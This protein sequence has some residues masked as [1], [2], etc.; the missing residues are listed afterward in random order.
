MSLLSL[1]G[2]FTQRLFG[3]VAPMG[4]V[5]LLLVLAAL[6]M[7]GLGLFRVADRGLMACAAVVCLAVAALLPALPV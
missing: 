6:I 7:G 2:S 4:I 1:S 3:Y 5:V